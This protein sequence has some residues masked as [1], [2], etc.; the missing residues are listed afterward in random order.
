MTEPFFP[1][2]PL[3]DCLFASQEGEKRGQT[4]DQIVKVWLKKIKQ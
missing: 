2:L 1:F 3:P 4:A